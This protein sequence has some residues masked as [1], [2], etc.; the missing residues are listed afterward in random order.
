MLYQYILW[1]QIFLHVSHNRSSIEHGIIPVSTTL[2][3][4]KHINQ[5]YFHHIY[6]CQW[7]SF[8][9]KID[10][11]KNIECINH[12]RQMI[13]LTLYFSFLIKHFIFLSCICKHVLCIWLLALWGK[14]EYSLGVKVNMQ[15][16]AVKHGCW[17]PNIG[18][19][20]E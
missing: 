4:F 10:T 15:L 20:Q 7:Q 6:V 3:Y 5:Y 16:Q 14:E 13:V 1:G 12:F 8:E 19:L 18:P 9:K 11:F 2:N 17:D